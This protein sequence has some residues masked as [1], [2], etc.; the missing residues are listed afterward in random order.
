LVSVTEIIILAIGL[1]TDA[2]AVSICKGMS[3]RRDI[4]KTGLD[5]GVWFGFFQA[6]MPF[7]GW[8]LGSTVS[9]HIEGFAP[10]IAF[11]LLAFL[12]IKMIYGAL[13]E[14]KKEKRLRAQGITEIPPEA[15]NGIGARTMFSFAIATSIDALAAGLSLAAVGLSFAGALFAVLSI[16]VITF[17]LSFIGAAAGSF[18]GTK[19][20]S[21]A[22]IAGGVMLL[23]IGFKILIEHLL[24]K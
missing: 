12:G 23:A 8:I 21:K 22:E 16:G 3:S 6:L 11:G 17:L 14:I 4:I 24:E 18:I 13:R 10:Y 5:C 9:K 20:K 7:L 2:F 1:S 15:D 19:L